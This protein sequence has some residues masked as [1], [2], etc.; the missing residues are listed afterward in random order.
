M[1]LRPQ[2]VR[3]RKEKGGRRL[4]GGLKGSVLEGVG[5]GVGGRAREGVRVWR[6]RRGWCLVRP[7]E[8]NVVWLHVSREPLITSNGMSF[9][10]VLQK[11]NKRQ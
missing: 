10:C 11:C 2:S 5:V 7:I 9:V 4:P 8:P 3:R 1:Q 6:W